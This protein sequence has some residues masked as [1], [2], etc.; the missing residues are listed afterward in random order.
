VALVHVI[1]KDH[2]FLSEGGR[3]NRLFWKLKV[4]KT[5]TKIWYKEKLARDKGNLLNLEADI[6][7]TILRLVG[8]PNNL[9]D[10]KIL[11]QLQS[12]RNLILT[13][14][15]EQWRLRSKSTWLESG[16][17]NTKFFHN[18]AIHSRNQKHIWKIIG[19]NH[20]KISDHELLKKE[21]VHYF[22]NFYMALTI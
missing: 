20:E 12:E 1:W 18:Y 14:I 4:L 17:N 21:A 22:Q 2:V 15:E 7:E 9:E 13:R 16:D 6:K 5:Q 19:E 8:D 11:R 3:K 10:S